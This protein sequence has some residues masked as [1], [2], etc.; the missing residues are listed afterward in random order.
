MCRGWTLTPRRTAEDVQLCQTK[1]PDG[2][3]ALKRSELFASPLGPIDPK[4]TFRETTRNRSS[5]AKRTFVWGR[6]IRQ[7]VFLALSGIE[8]LNI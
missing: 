4:L 1:T 2:G 8:R 5:G 7:R 3:S 6:H